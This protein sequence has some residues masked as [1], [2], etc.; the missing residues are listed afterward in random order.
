MSAN[1]AAK[2]GETA[3]NFNNVWI[4]SSVTSP[5]FARAVRD[6][7]ASNYAATQQLNATLSVHS[8]VTGLDYSMQCSDNGQFVI[9]T[10][11]NN[12]VVY[13]G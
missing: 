7:Y 10:G 11:G 4:G 3:G 5:Q 1:D 8:E 9:C 13:I 2:A 12:A 6:A